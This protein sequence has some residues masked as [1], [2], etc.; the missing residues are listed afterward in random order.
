MISCILIL[1]IQLYLPL[2]RIVLRSLC[3][4]NESIILYTTQS[5]ANSCTIDEIFSSISLIYNKNIRD[6]NTVPCETPDLLVEVYLTN[7]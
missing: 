4:H 7:V 2:L 6:P 3:K 5:S 1:H